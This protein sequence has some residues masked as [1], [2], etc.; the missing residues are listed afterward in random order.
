MVTAIANSVPFLYSVYFCAETAASGACLA[1]ELRNDPV[2]G[3]ALVAE[4]LL[5]RAKLPKVLRGLGNHILAELHNHSPGR[6][7]SNVYV[8]EHL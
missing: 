4:A 5:P 1:H 6:G 3:A 8:K 7:P 2:E